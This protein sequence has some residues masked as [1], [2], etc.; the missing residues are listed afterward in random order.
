MKVRITTFLTLIFLITSCKKEESFPMAYVSAKDH[1][2]YESQVLEKG[3]TIAYNQ[4]S[5]EFFDSPNEGEFLYTS[6]RMA[7]KYNYGRAYDDAYMCLTNAYH[8]KEYT[9]LDSLDNNTKNLALDLLE[10]GAITKN[11]DCMQRLGNYY[12]LGKYVEKDSV[13]G[14]HLL[15]E[16]K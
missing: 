5:M 4:L 11:K 3:D 14:Q 15:N 16:A 8:K 7:N 13:K 6:L 9:E 12:L 2:K 1:E 10:R